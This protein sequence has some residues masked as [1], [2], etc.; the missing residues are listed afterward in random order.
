MGRVVAIDAQDPGHSQTH[1]VCGRVV[2]LILAGCDHL[3]HTTQVIHCDALKCVRWR[4][5]CHHTHVV[6]FFAVR[7]I[8]PH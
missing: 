7:V 5:P 3:L 4:P 2:S 1:P 8:L 6:A